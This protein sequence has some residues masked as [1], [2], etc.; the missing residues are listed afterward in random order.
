MKVLRFERIFASALILALDLF[1]CS[2]Q[3]P[4]PA[5]AIAQ[6]GQQPIPNLVRSEGTL[7]GHGG[8]KLVLRFSVFAT[9]NDRD[10]LWNEEQLVQLGT[11]GEY[12]VL[13]GAGSAIG[14][15]Q[16]LFAAGEPRWLAVSVGDREESR[17][18]L[19][20]VPYALKA[21]DAETLSG[22]PAANFVTQR[23][24]D[25][26]LRSTAAALAAQ[27]VQPLVAASLTG[28]GTAGYVPLWTSASTLGNSS[29][30][31]TGS[32][33][34]AK[35]GVGLAAPA[36]TL[37]VNG[38][39]TLRGRL[40][41]LGPTSTATSGGNSQAL[42]FSA[43]SYKAGA[44]AVSQSYYL[45][46]EP[47]GND[48]DTPLSKLALLFAAGPASAV[49]TGLSIAPNGV[50]TFASGQTFPSS[51]TLFPH[52]ATFDAESFMTGSSTDWMLVA[53]NT[54][55]S[56][57]G[58]ILGQANANGIGIE[59]ASPGGVGVRGASN[60][61]TGISAQ[62]NTSGYALTAEN[63]GSGIAA[64]LWSQNAS[65][66]AVLVK[67]VAGGTALSSTA[68]N[69]YGGL[70]S[71][72][73]TY[74]AT[75]YATN[76]GNGNAGS[77]NNNSASRVALAG[78]NASIDL[79]A[80]ATYGSVING[81]AIYGTSSNG[82]GIYGTSLNQTGVHGDGF[83]IGV[84]GIASGGAPALAH[85]APANSAI[86]VHGSAAYTNGGILPIGVLGTAGNGVAG[87]F[88]NNSPSAFTLEVWADGTGSISDLFRTLMA[89][90]PDGVCGFGSRGTLT[91]TGQVKSLVKTAGERQV[92]TYSVQSAENWLEDYGSGQLI[93]GSA[94]VRLDPAFASTV[95]TGMEYHVFLT[96]VGD[97]KG[98]YLDKKTANSFE[99]HELGGGKSRVAF[100]YKIVAKR[101]GHESERLLDVTERLR[102]EM[103]GAHSPEKS[104]KP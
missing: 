14:L 28:A 48:T 64:Y 51:A 49:E 32:G 75:I 91:C 103:E 52:G 101:I 53:T 4:P 83:Y 57:K 67:N 102:A 88:E 86:G 100:D 16:S 3:E 2:A 104:G 81:K 66:P 43:S 22:Q 45:R 95:N 31:Q 23:Q 40:N 7:T 76:A 26:R 20:S 34:A 6:S 93:N 89:A 61:G 59:G 41:L 8:E 85:F 99:V 35:V 24:L 10:S 84:E 25:S 79:N 12:S 96:P 19:T 54:S 18:L 37:D 74:Q 94:I 98:L 11:H 21:A 78:V 90:T 30:F 69:G 13:L 9:E 15:P 87:Y 92:E 72:N 62:S 38:I 63:F 82:V 44:G 33:P 29:L 71:N 5:A 58:T 55:T 65:S 70:F 1:V 50:I 77:F 39:T 68:V 47:V 60:T 27:A 73:S 80:I 56:S 17:T 97:C 46:A 42:Q 36:T